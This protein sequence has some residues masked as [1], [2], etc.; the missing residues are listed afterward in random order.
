MNTQVLASEHSYSRRLAIARERQVTFAWRAVANALS[1]AGVEL[2]T[3]I[4]VLVLAGF[5]RQVWFSEVQMVLGGAW[6]VLPLYLGGAVLAKLLPGY[7]LGAVEELRRLIWLLVAVFSLAIVGI[8]LTG[9][10]PG[11]ESSR[12]TIGVAGVLALLAVPLSRIALKSMFI[13]H[14]FWGVPVVVYGA[15]RAGAQVVRQL[16]EERGMGYLPAAVFDDDRSRWGDFLDMVPIVGG[17]DR[18]TTEAAVAFLAMPEVPPQRQ[19]ELLEGPL[20]CY[21][22]VVIIPRVLDAPTLWVRPRDFVGLLGLEVTCNLTRPQPRLLKRTIDLGISLLGLPLWGSVVLISALLIWL[23][24]RQWPFFLQERI[25]A[26]GEVFHA[27][28]LRTM[29]ANADAVLERALK[30]DPALRKEWETYYK[31]E[32]DPRIT[33]IGRFLRKTSL[34]ELPQ[35]INVLSGEMSLVGPRPL[36][37]Y[38]HA[39]LG[40]R[41]RELRERV[42]PGITGLWQ[43]SGRSDSGTLGMERWDPYYVRNWSIWLDLVILVRTARVVLHGSGA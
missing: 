11:V 2:L 17:T 40:E 5:I 26:D 36:P 27:W 10:G 38:H 28:K 39:E 9:P 16:Q 42:R 24:D 3:L 12:L 4:G 25:G 8:W 1:L 33:G 14:D 22:T 41:V 23:N 32:N 21:G 31:L 6:V 30:S 37:R 43:V 29:V 35:L 18:V 19:V 15:G 34:D 7:G 13:R 20:S